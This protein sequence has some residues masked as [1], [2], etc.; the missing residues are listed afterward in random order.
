RSAD[1]SPGYSAAP[2]FHNITGWLLQRDS[3]PLS[4][5]PGPPLTLQAA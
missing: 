5:D 2:L 3:V 4:A 1:G